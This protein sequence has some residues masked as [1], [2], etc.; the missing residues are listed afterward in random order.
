MTK[1]IHKN[2]QQTIRI[3]QN[4]APDSQLLKTISLS[5]SPKKQAKT[6]IQKN[7]VKKQAE[8]IQVAKTIKPKR[9]SSRQVKKSGQTVES[10]NK[11]N[12]SDEQG[13]ELSSEEEENQVYDKEAD[14]RNIDLISDKSED[15]V[16]L[17]SLKTVELSQDQPPKD[18]KELSKAEQKLL[19]L[20]T[21]ECGTMKK[22]RGENKEKHIDAEE[23]SSDLDTN[24]MVK[25]NGD[26]KKIRSQVKKKTAR[27]TESEKNQVQNTYINNKPKKK[28]VMEDK[29]NVKK[30]ETSKPE[31]KIINIVSSNKK[32]KNM[33]SRHK[34]LDK[35]IENKKDQKPDL[36]VIKN[37]KSESKYLEESLGIDSK[38]RKTIDKSHLKG[39]KES[40]TAGTRNR[41]VAKSKLLEVECELLSNEEKHSEEYIEALCKVFLTSK[42]YVKDLYE[43]YGNNLVKLRGHLIAEKLV[44]LINKDK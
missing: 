12:V 21:K 35:K 41:K 36:E 17:V 44:S 9:A 24:S 6:K 14:N 25:K 30:A 2:K 15:N 16:D 20:T 7:N 13:E 3:N 34:S 31:A 8:K 40:L 29:L 22:A 19:S 11:K 43:R 26:K 23:L 27:T 37:K 28:I 33:S 38:K 32:L 10:F 42:D 5:S 18:E 39:S 1:A 4:K